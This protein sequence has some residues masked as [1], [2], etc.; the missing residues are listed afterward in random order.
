MQI[1][2]FH[3]PIHP[4]RLFV[5]FQIPLGFKLTV[6]YLKMDKMLPEVEETMYVILFL[7]ILEG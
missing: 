1:F 3:F 4:H 6:H 5:V 2:L 7:M